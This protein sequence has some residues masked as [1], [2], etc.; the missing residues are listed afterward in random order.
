MKDIPNTPIKFVES[1][2]HICYNF[3]ATLFTGLLRSRF[4]RAF[5][6]HTFHTHLK[7]T[8]SSRC[9]GI[10]LFM[11]FK[12]T[13]FTRFEVT[14][15]TRFLKSHFSC[16]F[17]FLPFKA[18]MSYQ[19]ANDVLYYWFGGGDRSKRPRWCGGSEEAAKEI[20][21]KFEALVS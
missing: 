12:V 1:T 4:S 11:P 10:A 14:L 3:E 2:W 21:E 6:S 9:F 20:R 19:E 15:F 7:V 13:R 8:P 16:A 18:K 5:R 17:R